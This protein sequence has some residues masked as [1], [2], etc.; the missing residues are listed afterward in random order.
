M[1]VWGSKVLWLHPIP[2][3]DPLPCNPKVTQW[4]QCPQHQHHPCPWAICAYASGGAYKPPSN[5]AQSLWAKGEL[6]RLDS[7][8]ERQGRGEKSVF[9]PCSW[10]ASLLLASSPCSWFSCGR[11]FKS[12]KYL[13]N[14][15][16]WT[17]PQ[18][19]QSPWRSPPALG[20]NFPFIETLSPKPAW[21]RCQGL[22]QQ[23]SK[24]VLPGIQPMRLWELC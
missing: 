14:T 4:I 15:N 7:S 11:I 2:G 19:Y 12:F 6:A 23:V 20:I 21:Q 16:A 1:L 8:E 22:S 18:T 17:L 13:K 3:Q 9:H 5:T 24:E 10:P